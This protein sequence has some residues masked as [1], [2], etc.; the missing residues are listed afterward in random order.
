MVL[1]HHFCMLSPINLNN[2][3]LCQTHEVH[4]ERTDDMLAAKFVSG[5]LSIT[6]FIPKQPFR[7]C[8]VFS[9]ITRKLLLQ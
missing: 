7:I 5:S 8:R 9:Q 1:I 4:N 3:L 2:Q 6:Q